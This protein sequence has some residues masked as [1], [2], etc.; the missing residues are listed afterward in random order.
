MALSNTKKGRSQ[1]AASLTPV[2]WSS[3]ITSLSFCRQQQLKH[4]LDTETAALPLSLS[5]SFALWESAQ[6]Q[7]Q[8]VWMPVCVSVCVCAAEDE[9]ASNKPF[10]AA[11]KHCKWESAMPASVHKRDAIRQL[12]E[13]RRKFVRV[14]VIYIVLLLLCRCAA[15]CRRVAA[16]MAEQSADCDCAR[17]SPA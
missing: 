4:M 13:R 15:R 12:R 6:V 1:L 2:R 10:P 16:I 9:D 5:L 3:L 8:F 17:N 14:C 11:I 7:S